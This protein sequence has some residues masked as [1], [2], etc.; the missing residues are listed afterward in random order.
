MLKNQPVPIANP[1]AIPATPPMTPLL[2]PSTNPA[3]TGDSENIKN[4]KN[5]SGIMGENYR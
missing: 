1:K 2:L 5:Q 3:A 4:N